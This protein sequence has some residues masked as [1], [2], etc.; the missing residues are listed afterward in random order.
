MSQKKERR[1]KHTRTEKWILALAR[2]KTHSK[3]K[4]RN[5]RGDF[6]RLQKIIIIIIIIIILEKNRKIRNLK[7]IWMES[8][9]LQ[10]CWVIRIIIFFFYFSFFIFTCIG[11][12]NKL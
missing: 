5:K 6:E 12:F 9:Q 11:L 3:K 1:R 4:Q 10:L 7:Y 8:F 2:I